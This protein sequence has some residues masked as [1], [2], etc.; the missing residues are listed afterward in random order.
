MGKQIR[1]YLTR[2][3]EN[4]FLKEVLALN[5]KLL[6]YIKSVPGQRAEIKITTD[7]DDDLNNK[8]LIL[9]LLDG[10]FEASE[11]K[12]YRDEVSNIEFCR[13]HYNDSKKTLSHGRIYFDTWHHN[14]QVCSTAY[15]KLKRLIKKKLIRYN[16]EDMGIV[17]ASQK[18]IEKLDNNE[19]SLSNL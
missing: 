15:D 14:N 10:N 1:F 17:Y 5:Y 6:T 19:L 9:I 18:V 4:D 8:W 7:F 13:S 12:D 2:E 3:E 11:V 16:S